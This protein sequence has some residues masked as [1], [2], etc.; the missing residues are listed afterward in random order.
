MTANLTM[1]RHV[2][3]LRIVKDTI[4]KRAKMII[5]ITLNPAID[6]IIH[7]K[8]F[9]VNAT[10]RI[11]SEKECLGG[12]GT[13][14]SYNL[15]LL[16]CKNIAMG[17]ALG[18][19]G[20]RVIYMLEKEGIQTRFIS[21]QYGN[22]RIN[23]VIVEDNGN[24]TL[25]CEKG[26][27][28]Q[29]LTVEAFLHLFKKSIKKDDI[30]VISGDA[31]NLSEELNE[32]LQ[33]S[34]METALRV[35][36]K[37]A[38]DSSGRYIKKGIKCR[39]FIIKPNAE[40]LAELTGLPT[41]TEESIVEA[42]RTLD[43]FDIEIIAVSRGEKGSVV[44]FRDAIYAVGAARVKPVNTV[45]SGDAYLSGLLDGLCRKLEIE[46]VLKRAAACGGAAAENEDTMGFDTDRITVLEKSICIRRIRQ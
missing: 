31:S 9:K 5:T 25:I 45:G 1:Q 15:T 21:D 3:C 19:M 38:L 34:M 46:D 12:K 6:Q 44:K 37:I 7:I 30:I 33:E 16:K 17:I 35:G 29:D 4:R 40:E 42:I 2:C 43:D 13:H 23:R 24:S 18:E 8:E 28:L 36:A 27:N 41:D 10:N 39:P 11:I 22:A 20:Q 32:F 26:T 14:I